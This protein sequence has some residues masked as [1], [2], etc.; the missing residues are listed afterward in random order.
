L[1][2]KL[3]NFNPHPETS[4]SIN[5]DIFGSLVAPFMFSGEHNIKLSH[6][7]KESQTSSAS[8]THKDI[9]VPIVLDVT[10]KAMSTVD[11]HTIRI[12]L[13]EDERKLAR[14]LERLLVRSGYGVSL[15]FDG[16][17]AIEAV[18]AQELHLIV[19]DINLPLKSGLE[20]LH[21]LRSSS[22]N[23]P[24]LI[25][26]ARDAMHDKVQGLDIGADDYL[27]KPFDSSELLARIQAILR[28]SGTLRTSILQVADLSMD[29]VKR[30]VARNGHAIN[31]TQT[32]FIL[33][34][35][36]MRNKDI[37]LTRKRIA[38]QVW[39]YKF[40]T[41]TNIVDVYISYLRDSIDKKFSPKLIQTVRGEGFMLKSS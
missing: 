35:F 39:G 14:S 2:D 8:Q 33:L 26:S 22:Y 9:R 37:V 38:E 12:L 7:F 27:T 28:R 36:F 19:L 29:I 18:S 21:H 5:L 3:R 23:T 17:A 25:L 11:N 32:E 20:V 1:G 16:V 13:V 40:E 30:S 41:G 4:N 10:F 15:A 31:L 6:R 24:V 34:E